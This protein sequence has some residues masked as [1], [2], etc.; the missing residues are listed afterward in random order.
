MW[1]AL[2]GTVFHGVLGD[3]QPGVQKFAIA[4]QHQLSLALLV[5][6]L[7]IGLRFAAQRSGDYLAIVFWHGWW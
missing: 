2:A 4:Y 3:R 6:M 7:T 1:L 5:L